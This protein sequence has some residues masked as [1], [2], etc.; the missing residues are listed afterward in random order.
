MVD[1]ESR[2]HRLKGAYG[3]SLYIE[4]E[5]TY[6]VFD[7]GPSSDLLQLNAEA[8]NVDM[9]LIDGVIVSHI[10]SDHVGGMPYIGWVSPYTK[11]YIPYDSLLSLGRT[12]RSH[13]LVPVE[14]SEWMNPWPSVYVSKPVS[15]PPWEHF[16][17]IEDSGRLV[18]FS[19]CMHPGVAKT[20][21]E[22]S[23][24]FEGKRIYGVIGGFHL[25]NA[26]KKHVLKAI[27][28]LVYTYGV[29][30]VVPLHCS[31]ELFKSILSKEYPD[32]YVEAGVGATVEF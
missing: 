23:T 6:L 3:L 10:H 1:N 24:Y 8:L 12:A 22:I 5:T 28:S 27:D 19:G 20:L 32:I 17:V 16:L 18:V 21:S 31:G 9:E 2:N 7:T 30:K 29:R 25:A 13:G 14:V 15:G 26:P 11:V 4:Y